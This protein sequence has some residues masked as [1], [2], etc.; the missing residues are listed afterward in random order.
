[1]HKIWHEN[2]NDDNEIII[3]TMKSLIK[4]KNTSFNEMNL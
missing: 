1:M 3:K 2:S 4:M